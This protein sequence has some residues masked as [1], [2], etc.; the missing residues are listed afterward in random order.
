M[1]NRI[2]F[3]AVCG[4]VALPQRRAGIGGEGF[5]SDN[6]AINWEVSVERSLLRRPHTDDDGAV[7]LGRCFNSE[8]A[9]AGNNRHSL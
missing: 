4:R 6:G 9:R 5:R 2:E 8:N 1:I 7:V 3:F